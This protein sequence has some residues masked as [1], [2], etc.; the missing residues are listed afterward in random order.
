MAASKRERERRIHVDDRGRQDDRK[1]ARGAPKKPKAQ[2]R[3]QAL[4]ESGAVEWIRTT[5]L[6]ITNNQL[7]TNPRH[8]SVCPA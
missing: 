7:R 1:G 3:G 6:L 2:P 4:D 5:D 8:L